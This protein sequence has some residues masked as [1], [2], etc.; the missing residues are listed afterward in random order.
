MKLTVLIEP[1]GNGFHAKVPTLPGCGTWGK[2]EK[3]ALEKIREAILLYLQ[4][5][6]FSRPTAQKFMR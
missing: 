4:P 3:E 2:T 5:M 1:D 6:R